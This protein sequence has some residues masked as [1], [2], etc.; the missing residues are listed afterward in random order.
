MSTI[1]EAWGISTD[2]LQRVDLRDWRPR[3]A[4]PVT[5]PMSAFGRK[6]TKVAP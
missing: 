2:Y 6:R 1:N 4:F 3:R 5:E